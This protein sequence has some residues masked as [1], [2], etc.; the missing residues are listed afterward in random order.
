MTSDARPRT[1]T[2]ARTRDV[3]MA[4]PRMDVRDWG[5]ASAF[6]AEPCDRGRRAQAAGERPHSPFVLLPGAQLQPRRPRRLDATGSEGVAR[7]RLTAH[8]LDLEHVACRRVE[9]RPRNETDASGAN[10]IGR[11]TS[12]LQSQSNLVCRLLLEKKKK[13]RQSANM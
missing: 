1:P 10:Q 13:H 7:L 5:D 9:Q 2:A 8:L 11:H 6:D 4:P 12:E 3:R